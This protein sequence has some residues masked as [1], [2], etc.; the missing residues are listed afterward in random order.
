MPV[1]CDTKTAAAH[2]VRKDQSV[3]S[4]HSCRRHT[5]VGPAKHIRDALPAATFL[6]FTGT[7]IESA[8]KSTRSVFGDYI[9]VYDLTR[10]VEDGATVTLFYESRLAKVA[11]SDADMAALDQL[12]A[13][14]TSE[15]DEEEA[16]RTKSKWA[17]L[18]AIVGAED[19]L[20]LIAADIVEQWE[21][22]REAMLGKAMIVTM[23]R[24][25]AVRLYEKI[26][27]L[28]S[29]WH[30]DDPAT[31][32]IEVVMTGS[33][34]DP[35]AFQPHLYS[36]DVRREI[37]ARA[38]DPADPLEIVI[39][40]DMWLTGFDSPSLHTTYVDKTMAGAGLMQAIAL[41]NRTF[42]DLPAVARLAEHAKCSTS[43]WPTPTGRRASSTR[44]SRWSGRT[45]WQAP[46]RRPRRSATTCD[47]SP[48]CA[49]RIQAHRHED[50]G[51]SAAEAAFYDAI[52]QNESAVME[53]GDEKVKKISV[54]LVASVR[55]SVTID[56][57][58]KESVKAGLRAKV[59]R[60]LAI[61]VYPPDLEERAV[62][63]VLEQAEL[64][65]GAEA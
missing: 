14:I 10:A 15:V 40:R 59:R 42:R 44:S 21:H 5:G 32:R 53:L 62:E 50:L 22:R 60:L 31:G 25:I 58:Y 7:P 28:R 63:L 18:E 24:R 27:A 33:T 35:S 3:W 26:V 41:V 9:D 49:R 19:R 45:R 38:K 64:F 65:A 34:A 8:D 1:D 47:C 36:K 61:N 12:A 43:S 20:D 4:P 57:N 37:K 13:E 39:V 29:D 11:L 6:R 48:T 2:V 30:S 54:D 56:W 52:V 23:S 55:G 17:R 16:T 51:L 46:A